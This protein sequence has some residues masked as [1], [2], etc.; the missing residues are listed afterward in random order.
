M[1][2]PHVR[3]WLAIVENSEVDLL[4]GT[5]LIDRCIRYS[6]PTERKIVQ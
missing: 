6:F 4:P 1:G 3:T 5:S 2:E